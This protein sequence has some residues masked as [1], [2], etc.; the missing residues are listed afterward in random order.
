[1]VSHPVHLLD[2]M[3]NVSLS[4]FVPFC[5]FQTQL[6][7]SK[8][9]TFLPDSP[10]PVCKSF[11]PVDLHGQLCYSIR[12]N[13]TGKNRKKGGLVLV[14]DMNNDRSLNFGHSSRPKFEKD[15]T[16]MR[17]AARYREVAK[18]NAKIHI[19]LLTPFDEIGGGSYKMTSV[20]KVKGTEAFLDMQE[21]ERE[22]RLG[23]AE[24]CQKGKM[25]EQCKCVPW[26]LKSIQVICLAL[27]NLLLS[28]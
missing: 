26:E 16:K 24:G 5:A 17:F 27:Q 11:V 14:L 13:M 25:Y 4:T 12:V 19:Q 23:R 7:I 3:G 22:C 21:S 28:F 2:Q 9:F 15:H 20:K 1:M 6:G 8:P 18:N 10:Y